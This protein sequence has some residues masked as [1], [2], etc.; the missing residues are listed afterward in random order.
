MCLTLGACVPLIE[1]DRQLL[2][3]GSWELCVADGFPDSDQVLDRCFELAIPGGWESAVPGYD[4]FGR[5]RTVFDGS[6][7]PADTTLGIYIEQIRDADKV[8]I[9]GQLIGQTGEF[10]PAFQKATLYPRLYRIPAGVLSPGPNQI[11]VWVYNNARPGGIYAQAPVIDDYTVLRTTIERDNYKTL[12]F[13]TALI[14]FAL[15]HLVYFF[16]RRRSWDNLSYAVF[17]LAWSIYVWTYSDFARASGLSL[18]FLFRSNVALFF[19]IFASFPWF[20]YAFFNCKLP[21]VMKVILG[22]VTA[23]IGFVMVVPDLDLIY[24]VLEFVEVVGVLLALPLIVW[25]LYSSIR[26]RRPYARVF[27]V[28]LL[29]YMAVGLVDILLDVTALALPFIRSLLGPYALLILST[30]LTFIMSHKHWAYYREATF[31]SLTGAYR[32][33]AFIQQVDQELAALGE[34]ELAL[35]MVDLDDFKQ[36]NDRHGHLVGDRLLGEVAGLFRAQLGSTD[37]FGRFGGDEFCVAIVAESEPAAIHRVAQLHAALNQLIVSEL[38]AFSV[39]ATTG[40]VIFEAEEHHSTFDLIVHADRALIK[41]KIERKGQ[42][43][44]ATVVADSVE[45]SQDNKSSVT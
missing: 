32:R 25:A 31:D 15:L 22:F 17:L 21:V 9:N 33:D 2:L 6:R 11:E 40:A 36:I 18:N 34:S 38:P 30:V 27:S 19:A 35:M 24:P 28:V 14:V 42:L 20:V 29:L 37:H 1:S 44:W 10:P 26:A 41:T 43:S 45:L 13:V 3:G 8:Y 12:I 7:L 16:F 39:S 23:S 4:G 5:L